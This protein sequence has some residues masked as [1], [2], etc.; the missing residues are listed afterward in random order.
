MV[1]LAF[2]ALTGSA[3]AQNRAAVLATTSFTPP[4]PTRVAPGDI[5]TIYAAGLS[6]TAVPANAD[7]L[8]LPTTLGG[9]SA[10]IEQ[11]A[12]MVAAVPLISVFQIPTC[13]DPSD[14]SASCGTL[15]GIRLQVPFEA[16]AY[17]PASQALVTLVRLFVTDQA[18][19]SAAV[20]LFPVLDR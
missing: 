4:V 6:P 3:I 13:P 14:V 7:H 17:N 8:P 1:V 19:N 18:G 11:F 15:T 5:I 2:C 16:V 20:D 10:S 12:R 9:I